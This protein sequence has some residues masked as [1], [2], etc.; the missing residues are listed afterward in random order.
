MIKNTVQ[1]Q[2]E[3]NPVL[4]LISNKPPTD[5]SRIISLKQ[6]KIIEDMMY[7][8]QEYSRKSKDY[9]ARALQIQKGNIVELVI[10]VVCREF[11]IDNPKDI[12]RKKAEGCLY[13]TSGTLAD[14]KHTSMYI[15]SVFL[16]MMHSKEINKIFNCVSGSVSYGVKKITY[17]Q[18]TDR[19]LRYRL[20]SIVEN[21][22]FLWE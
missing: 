11:N 6:Q 19:K 20:D 14:A 8:S 12:Y 3:I 13:N 15:L 22:R 17:L 21:L 4:T 5:T 10:S 2:V 18:Q 1:S 16:K 7:K 9:R